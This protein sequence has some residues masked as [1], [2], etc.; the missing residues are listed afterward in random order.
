M[1]GQRVLTCP[2]ESSHDLK[3]PNQPKPRKG[4]FR[5]QPSLLCK[6][7]SVWRIN[8]RLEIPRELVPEFRMGF[9][10]S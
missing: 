8:L 10:K 5:L 6:S 1:G 9:D 7:R 2:M 3:S 4:G